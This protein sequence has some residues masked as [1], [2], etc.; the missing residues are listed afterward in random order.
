MASSAL[1]EA[2]LLATFEAVLVTAVLVMAD[3]VTTTSTAILVTAA[4]CTVSVAASVA[5]SD[6]VAMV[7]RVTVSIIAVLVRFY[8]AQRYSSLSSR[9]AASICELSDI[10]SRDTKVFVTVA[11]AEGSLRGCRNLQLHF[12]SFSLLANWLY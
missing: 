8:I 6:M 11:V 2:F 5:A 12:V 7:A 1:S 4:T 9:L 3:M 10:L